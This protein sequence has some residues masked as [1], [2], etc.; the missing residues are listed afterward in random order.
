MKITKL[1]HCCMIIEEGGVRVL[2]D[3]GDYS[4]AQNTATGIDLVLIT[5]EHGDHC[6]VLS[7]KTVLANNPTAK[8]YTNSAVGKLLEQED[9]A[10]ELLEHGDSAAGEVVT[11]QAFGTE[12]REMYPGVKNVPNTGYL[13]ANKFFPKG[14]LSAELPSDSGLLPDICR[15]FYFGK[16]SG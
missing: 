13:I 16:T 8:V 4:E 3:P 11:I 14:F 10:Y 7:L 6:H 5:H 1:G 15:R 9:V 2:T 12:H